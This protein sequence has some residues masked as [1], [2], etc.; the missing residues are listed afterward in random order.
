[1]LS[2]I[3][4]FLLDAVFPQYCCA[5]SR[6]GDF[7]CPKCLEKLYFFTMPIELHLEETY[8]DQLIAA[9]SYEAPISQ[10]IFAMK[11]KHVKPIG[12]YCGQLLYNSTYFPD[13]ECVAAVPLHLQRQKQRGYN[14]AEVIAR[15]LSQLT[16]I[17]YIPLLQ[18]TKNS[19]AQA[20]IT[21]RVKRLSNLEEAFAYD[22]KSPTPSSV[23]LIDDVSTTGTTLNECAKI[24]KQH[25]V[26]EVVGLVV[27]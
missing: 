4:S 14:Q 3:G 26:R 5:C 20:T 24:L 1:M 19:V 21:D 27:A 16:G 12:E 9:C 10:L 17:P 11:Y 15:K 25:G 23:L 8:L 6:F 18:R 13:T 7:L 2:K 22:G